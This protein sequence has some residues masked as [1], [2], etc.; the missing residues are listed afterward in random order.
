MNRD[1]FVNT[2]K[3]QIDQWNA[4]IAKLEGQM[5]AAS[6]DM[7]RKYA[8]A[9]AETSRYRAEAQAKLAEG[10]KKSSDSWDKTRHDMEAAWKDIADGFHKA[11]T[12]FS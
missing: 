7:E 4:D 11:W 5:K 8:D 1:E 2:L 12:R 3:S 10:M 6:G 9:I